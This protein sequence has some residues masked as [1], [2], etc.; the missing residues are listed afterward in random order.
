ML[1]RMNTSKDRTEICDLY[2][3]LITK[4]KINTIVFIQSLVATLI[5]DNE[6]TS[7]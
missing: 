2:R 5:D 7:F 3:T 6:Q 1:N 4:R